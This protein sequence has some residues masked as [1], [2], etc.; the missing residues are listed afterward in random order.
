MN[1]VQLATQLPL[2]VIEPDLALHVNMVC[3]VYFTSYWEENCLIR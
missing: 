2:R 1:Y 3:P